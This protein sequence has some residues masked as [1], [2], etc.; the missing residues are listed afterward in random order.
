M[1]KTPE[2]I[3]KQYLSEKAK[4]RWADPEYRA[5]QVEARHKRW[6]DPIKRERHSEGQRKRWAKARGEK[7]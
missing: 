3:T 5:R 2:E 4:A 6:E 7:S 1:N